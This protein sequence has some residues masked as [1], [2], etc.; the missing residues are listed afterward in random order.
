LPIRGPLTELDREREPGLV[1]HEPQQPRRIVREAAGV[2]HPQAA[3]GEVVQ[4]MRRGPNAARIRTGEHHG[5]RVDGEVA[6]QEIVGERRRLDIRQRSRLGVSL[7]PGLGQVVGEAVEG[8]GRRSEP[9]VIANAAAQPPGECCDIAF[10]DQV[11]IPG[12]A[13][14]QQIAHRPADQIQRFRD[15]VAEPLKQQRTGRKR[16]DPLEHHGWPRNL[17]GADVAGRAGRSR[18]DC[19]WRRLALTN[20]ESSSA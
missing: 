3:R 17:H 13:V 8:D 11:E 9:V 5:D 18:L 10:D 4:R 14:Q 6:T 16:P 1:T 2:Q 12:A 20:A 7:A 15:G 19:R